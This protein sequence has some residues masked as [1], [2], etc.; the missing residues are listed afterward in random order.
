MVSQSSVWCT[1]YSIWQWRVAS[2]CIVIS[3]S[4][5]ADKECKL[6]KCMRYRYSII[7]YFYSLV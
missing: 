5:I 4:E 7:L 2:V 1:V 6:F 3:D